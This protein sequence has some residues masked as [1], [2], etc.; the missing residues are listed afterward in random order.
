LFGSQQ[1][2]FTLAVEQYSADTY[3]SLGQVAGSSN[4][5][6]NFIET[7]FQKVLKSVEVDLHT[8]SPDVMVSRSGPATA[9]RLFAAA[10]TTTLRSTIDHLFDILFHRF[11]EIRDNRGE[12]VG[13]QTFVANGA[14]GIG[15]LEPTQR[16]V[17]RFAATGAV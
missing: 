16:L 12:L 14:S 17:D 2:D 7:L 9:G 3:H 13:R 8:F 6:F 11:F 4:D 1:L 5:Q 10:A 15:L